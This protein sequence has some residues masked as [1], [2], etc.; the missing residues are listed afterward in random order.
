M[1]LLHGVMPLHCFSSFVV[2]DCIFSVFESVQ[3]K[4]PKAEKAKYQPIQFAD[5]INVSPYLMA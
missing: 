3:S 2:T 1:E 4:V 5:S